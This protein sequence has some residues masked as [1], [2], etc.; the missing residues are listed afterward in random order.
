MYR[1]IG[2]GLT[3]TIITKK[4]QP[5]FGGMELVCGAP[6]PHFPIIPVVYPSFCNN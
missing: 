3:L 4:N 1:I 5:H 2:M 6:R